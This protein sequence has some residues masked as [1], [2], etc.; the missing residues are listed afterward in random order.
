M[1]FFSYMASYISGDGIVK[2]TD[3]ACKAN[4]TNSTFNDVAM[5][6]V[7]QSMQGGGAAQTVTVEDVDGKLK[8]HISSK[9]NILLQANMLGAV[10]N[11]YPAVTYAGNMVAQFSMSGVLK[12]D[13]YLEYSVHAQF[14]SDGKNVAL[15]CKVTPIA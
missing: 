7:M 10:I 13:A 3:F 1:N 6:L 5:Q 11:Y 14:D 9:G 15:W 8:K 2:L 12:S 4:G